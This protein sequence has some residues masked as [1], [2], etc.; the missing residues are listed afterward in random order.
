MATPWF[1]DYI[2][3]CVRSGVALVERIPQLLSMR[4]MLVQLARPARAVKGQS[5]SPVHQLQTAWSSYLFHL[6]HPRP[7]HLPAR[8][9]Y[10]IVALLTVRGN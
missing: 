5:S 2:F 9:F 10:A 1:S 6:G 7:R 4:H 3:V 8:S